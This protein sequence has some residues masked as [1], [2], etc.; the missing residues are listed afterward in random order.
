MGDMVLWCF[1]HMVLLKGLGPKIS[2]GEMEPV[3]MKI[4]ALSTALE[5]EL[6]KFHSA[7]CLWFPHWPII[8]HSSEKC[9]ERLFICIILLI[10]SIFNLGQVNTTCETT[11]KLATHRSKAGKC[12]RLGKTLKKRKLGAGLKAE[13][14]VCIERITWERDTEMVFKYLG[15]SCRDGIMNCY[16]CLLVSDG[17]KLQRR[18]YQAGSGKHFTAINC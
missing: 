11:Q 6:V 7:L 18:R 5:A 3:A 14:L 13:G 17:P 1:P 4:L 2:G 15:G 12:P 9:G 16:S 8:P 10:Y